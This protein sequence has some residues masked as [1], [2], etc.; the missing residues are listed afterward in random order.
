MQQFGTNPLGLRIRLVDLVDRHDHRHLRR[1]RVID[2]FDRLRHH[3]I[4]GSHNKHHNIRH[5]RTTRT[6]LREGGVTRRIDKGDLRTRRRDNLI[7]TD[8]LRNT[9]GFATRDICRADR[10]QQRC[11]AMI[12]MA[13]NR[14]NRRTCLRVSA[15]IRRI[16]QAFFD[17]RF[18]NALHRM[19]EFFRNNLRRIGIDHIRDLHHL[20]LLHQKADQIDGTFRHAVREFLDRDRF[21]NRDF[22]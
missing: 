5:L 22:A 12:D 2:R 1:F 8:M 21:R 4:I 10:I 14:D 9:A 17:V 20:A 11:L 16:E 3:A 6:H 19:A 18:S 7:G 13:H 15:N